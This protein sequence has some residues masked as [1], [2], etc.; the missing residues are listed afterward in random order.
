ML[1]SI[2][3]KARCPITGSS[4][5]DSPS[6]RESPTSPANRAHHS[7]CRTQRSACHTLR[8]PHQTAGDARTAPRQTRGRSSARHQQLGQHRP[9]PTPPP[10]SPSRAWPLRRLT[11]SPVVAGEAIFT[12][13]C[14][15]HSRH[16]IQNRTEQWAARMTPP[17][18]DAPARCVRA[19]G[20]RRTP[21]SSGA[22]AGSGTQC[23][24]RG[25]GR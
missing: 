17:A 1:S 14:A 24:R 9:P 15:F 8:P 19:A 20:W 23:R 5:P 21:R 3:I 16:S 22:R 25:S 18:C 13:A 4:P 10:P 12:R 7:R 11:A 2:V 6:A